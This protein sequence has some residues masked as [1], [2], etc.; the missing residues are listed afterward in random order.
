MLGNVLTSFVAVSAVAACARFVAG[1]CASITVD[2][3]TCVAYIRVLQCSLQYVA[4][5]KFFFFV[6]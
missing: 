4:Y 1:G 2:G 3:S 5:I 6:Y